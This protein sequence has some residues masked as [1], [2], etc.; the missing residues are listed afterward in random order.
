MKPDLISRRESIRNVLLF[1]CPKL[2]LWPV[3]KWPEVISRA[4]QITFDWR[5]RLGMLLGLVWVTWLLRPWASLQGQS[6]FLLYG[7]RAVIA[8]LLLLV[9]IGPFFLRKMGRGL[10]RE[11]QRAM[12]ADKR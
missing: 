8:V 5:E 9:C 7:A 12:L 3:T 10:D 1:L 11:Y 6:L 4:W 2:Y